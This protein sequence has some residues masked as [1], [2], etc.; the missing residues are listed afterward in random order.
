MRYIILNCFISKFPIFSFNERGFIWITL[1]TRLHLLLYTKRESESNNICYVGI[2]H[3]TL[4]D[5]IFAIFN[6]Y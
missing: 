2:I 5:I 1:T 3:Y 6:A 4:D